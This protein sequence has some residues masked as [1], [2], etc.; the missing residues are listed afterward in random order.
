M[1]EERRRDDQRIAKLMTDMDTVKICLA[2]NTEITTQVRDILT[3]FRVMALFAKWI[4]AVAAAVAGVV[5][6]WHSFK[7]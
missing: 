1:T 5:A 3:S 4:A 7:S 2:S 6:A